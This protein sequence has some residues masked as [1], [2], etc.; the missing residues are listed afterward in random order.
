MGDAESEGVTQVGIMKVLKVIKVF[1]EIRDYSGN[2]N[3][4]KRLRAGVLSVFWGDSIR[5]LS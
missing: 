2:S 1:K 4:R 3:Y 5:K